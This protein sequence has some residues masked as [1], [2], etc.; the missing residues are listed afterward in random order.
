MSGPTYANDL[1]YGEANYTLSA[2][3]AAAAV[4]G[5]CGERPVYLDGLC[6]RDYDVQSYRDAIRRDR[7]GR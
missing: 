6:K 1:F 4:C 2:S 3:P 7:E 5:E